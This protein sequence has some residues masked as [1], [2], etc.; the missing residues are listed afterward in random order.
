[1]KVGKGCI[2]HSGRDEVRSWKITWG[3]K[4]VSKL[5]CCNESKIRSIV[6]DIMAIRNER[7]V[8]GWHNIINNS[9]VFYNNYYCYYYFKLIS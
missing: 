3:W 7:V 2:C 4:V 6:E 8:R 9:L 1:M 5:W